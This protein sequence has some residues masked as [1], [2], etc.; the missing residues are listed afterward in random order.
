MQL[1]KGKPIADGLLLSLKKDIK[2]RREKPGLAVILVGA[3]PASEI[4]VNL[5]AKAARRAGIAFKLI[6]FGAGAAESKILAAIKKLN[7]DRKID[8]VIV[9]LPLPKK[10]HTQKI[11][12]VIDPEKDADGFHPENINKFLARESGVYPV[13]PMAIMKL[14]EAAKVKLNVKNAVVIANSKEFGSVMQQALKLKQVKAKYILSKDFDK[15]P[16]WL[17]KADIVVTA[18]GKAGLV[19][20]EMLKR[21]TIVVD[22]GITKKDGKVLGDVDFESVKTVARY[23]SPVPGGV[24]PVTIACLLQ[25]V[26]NLS[27]NAIKAVIFDMDG[28][29]SDTEKVYAAVESDLLGRYGINFSVEEFTDQYAGVPSNVF[30]KEILDKHKIKAD[31]N[32]LVKE[33]WER[34]NRAVRKRVIPMPG[35]F[36]LIDKCERRKLKLA[37]GTSS[38]PDFAWTILKKLGIE[39]KFEAVVTINDVKK[40]KPHPDIFLLAA[41]KL[42]VKPTNCLV[43]ED[44]RSGMTAAKAAGMKCIGLVKNKNSK[45]YPADILVENLSEIKL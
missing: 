45:D 5:K 16:G 41:K 18:V 2:G 40:G 30:L 43:I 15:K 1:L 23:L 11:I 19:K 44:G 32:K 38:K 10:F 9:Q 36:K 21:G 25:N 26:A 8:G 39:R 14:L 34:V 17:K 6:R 24:G 4:Y 28:V 12:N 22:G 27:K 37:V 13:F 31:V 20:D 3:D 29:L 35:V 42:G 33:K 7:T